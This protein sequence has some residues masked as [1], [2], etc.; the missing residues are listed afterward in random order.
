M[1]RKF[2]TILIVFAF[3]MMGLS[4][5]TMNAQWVLAKSSGGTNSDVSNSVATDTHGNVFITGY[6]SSSSI[7]FGTT[8]LI[9]DTSGVPDIFIAKYDNS[10]NVLWAKRAGGKGDDEGKSIATDAWG[11]V[12]VTGWFTS[13][14]ITFGT[15]TLVNAGAGYGDIFVVK[16]D[17]SGNFKW[18][19][20]AG[21]TNDDKGNGIATDAHGNVVVTG[22][23]FSTSIT[24]D[25][26]TLTSAGFQDIYLVKY[27]SS[28]NVLWA[29][30]AG[31]P[32]YDLAY[33]VATDTSGN[34]VITGTFD[35][36]SLVFG[37]STLLNNGG[38]NIFVAKYD[39]TGN[40]LWAQLADGTDEDKAY[41][42]ATDVSGNVFITGYF[43]DNSIAF[44]TITL[45][46]LNQTVFVAKYTSSGNIKW[47]KTGI[48]G[49]D[50]AN[51]IVTDRQGN[52]YITGMYSSNPIT[53]GSYSLTNAGNY[54]IF[55]VKYDSSGNVD[56]AKRAG[57][58]DADQ[59]N[60]IALDTN[61]NVFV[62]GSFSSPSIVFG[63][64]TLTNDTTDGTSDIFVGELSRYS[65]IPNV[66]NAS[67]L[68]IYPNPA[69]S[70]L[71]IHIPTPSSNQQLIIT[72]LLG[73]EVYK[74]ML[75]GIDN[76]ISIS[77]WSAGI[78]FYEVRS[79]NS[80]IRGKFVKE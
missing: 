33:G 1:K 38:Y 25:T 73:T 61:T 13:D 22:N 39:A 80:S 62:T 2:T 15:T 32:Y 9:N 20:R 5:Q 44:D 70:I 10:G 37:T 34:I 7:T 68:K 55:V 60:G 78:Y 18:A 72:D 35:S 48:G 47:A 57:G 54:D 27:D 79:N 45:H 58:I 77:T 59:G 31:G 21:G 43:L 42:I 3:V 19:K 51:G 76:T 63:S 66:I 4:T 40:P 16:Y 50:Y 56:W 69:S 12:Y 74:E 30:D 17:S 53:F 52:A 49:G 28:G 67:A 11:N 41:A 29:K 36:P 23:Y 24:F 71:N 8:T 26:I 6:F 75:T 65:G 46:G 64:T 14:S